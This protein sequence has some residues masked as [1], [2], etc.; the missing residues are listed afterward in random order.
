[1]QAAGGN[2]RVVVVGLTSGSVQLDASTYASVLFVV[3]PT[4]A[5]TL[6]IAWGSGAVV[7]GKWVEVRVEQPANGP[8]TVS[9][10]GAQWADKVPG[11]V[12]A[13]ASAID[14]FGYQFVGSP[15]AST[16]NG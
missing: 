11:A 6:T 12:T 1:M 14:Q 4:A 15:G 9:L 16:V 5:M 13:V 7:Q 8:F 10:P 2:Q 3:R